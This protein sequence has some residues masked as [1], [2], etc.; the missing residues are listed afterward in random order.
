VTREQAEAE[1]QEIECPRKWHHLSLLARY[2]QCFSDFIKQYPQQIINIPIRS[3]SVHW[4]KPHHQG[5]DV[6]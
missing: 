4:A 5:V 2:M 3:A 6:G 1:R